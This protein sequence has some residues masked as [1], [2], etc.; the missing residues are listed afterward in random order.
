MA[1]L[2]AAKTPASDRELHLESPPPGPLFQGVPIANLAPKMHAG[3]PRA[4]RHKNPAL[5]PGGIPIKAG[6]LL[7]RTACTGGWLCP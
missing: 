1:A 6:V 3:A 4:T 5:T 7:Y 2:R